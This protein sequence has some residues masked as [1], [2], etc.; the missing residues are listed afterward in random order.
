MCGIC[1][2]IHSN[3]KADSGTLKKMC[4]YLVHRGPD[5][6]GLFVEDN[7]ALGMRR[8]SIIDIEGGNQPIH[9][10]KGDLLLVCNGEIYNFPDLR[11]QL[12]GKGHTFSTRSDAE[13][14]LH[15]YEDTGQDCV[16]H[17]EGMFSFA[18]FDRAKKSLML[19]RDRLGKKPLYYAFFPGR[20]FVFSSEMRS[21][22]AYG[23]LSRRLD[24]DALFRYFLFDYVPEPHSIF[25]G[26]KKLTPG[27]YLV[28]HKGELRQH[29]YWNLYDQPEQK[30]VKLSDAEDHV[31]KLIEDAVAKRLISDVP[32]G[33]FLSGG[34]DSSLIAAIMQSKTGTPVKAFSIN[35]KE[36]SFDE[37][38]YAQLA[39]KKLGVELHTKVFSSDDSVQLI[40]E[41]VSKSSEPFADPSILP[42]YLLSNFARQEVTVALSGDAGD[43]VFA[44]YPT[45]QA[46]RLARCLPRLLGSLLRPLAGLIPVSYDNISLDFKV[47]KF[48]EGLRFPLEKRNQIWLG[49]F[50]P[51][52]IKELVNE[53][54]E[55]DE[56]QI[57]MLFQPITEKASAVP[58]RKWLNR[59]LY[60]DIHF[61]L[62]H[63]MFFKID[64]ASMLNSLEVRCPFADHKLV[65]YM[66]T[67]PPAFK[68]RGLK[69]KYILKRIANRH[70]PSEIV[71]RPKKGFGIPV[72]HWFRNELKDFASSVLFSTGVEKDFI[73]K[74]YVEQLWEE[75]QR[76]KKD[77]RKMLWNL[78]I[79]R[80]WHSH[81]STF[82]PNHG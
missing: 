20:Y 82:D 10:E 4:S 3:E 11:K 8:L 50:Y 15:L 41:V 68:M 39:A 81:L 79:F 53:W 77:N 44:G 19:A 37:S 17:L 30:N 54:P 22:L 75:H 70:L 24:T 42:T 35:F 59:I 18:L 26:I 16:K 47:K 49:A 13:V 64:T 62:S 6:E 2:Y 23:K 14:I 55:D 31:E 40:D 67:L 78:F 80:L 7:V 38:K 25:A 63:N 56:A 72:G 65:E 51:S 61:Y 9:S 33:V 60:Q 5:S 57:A 1:G 71:N 21:L 34:I 28:L 74:K 32:L 73:N 43:E 52:Q 48:L 58:D 27:N 66:F 69:T 46:H 12:I 29:E 45:Y 76:G 36:K